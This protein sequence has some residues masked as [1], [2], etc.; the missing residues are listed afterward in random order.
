MTPVCGEY[1]TTAQPPTAKTAKTNGEVLSSDS[2]RNVRNWRRRLSRPEGRNQIVSGSRHLLSGKTNDSLCSNYDNN[3]KHE[4]EKV[5]WAWGGGGGAMFAVGDRSRVWFS[6]GAWLDG[7]WSPLQEGTSTAN[8]EGQVVAVIDK[9]R[10]GAVYS[11]L[12]LLADEP[13]VRDSSTLEH[14]DKSESRENHLFLV[15]SDNLWIHTLQYRFTKWRERFVDRRIKQ[16]NQSL[17][18]K[19][20]AGLIWL[21]RECP[22]TMCAVAE[23]SLNLGSVV[24]AVV[25]A[26]VEI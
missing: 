17:R 20:T 3:R 25:G 12:F 22:E 2:A 6:S 14:D 9:F 5:E 4:R 15:V 8:S 13:E 16:F 23:S 19:W 11:M 1:P 7:S 18:I 24:Y 26:T 21:A 10:S